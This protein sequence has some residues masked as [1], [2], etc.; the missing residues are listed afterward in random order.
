MNKW[1]KRFMEMT[2]LVADWSSCYKENRKVGA[3]IVKNKR[4]LTTGYNGAPAGIKSCM[5]R[6]ECLRNKLNIESGKM[7]EL[8]YA[9][10]A[11]QNAIIQAARLGISLEGAEL[12]CTHQPCVIC[13]KMIINSGIVRVV[14]D[15]GYPDDFALELFAESGVRLELYS[16]LEKR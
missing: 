8:C 6:G 15:Q 5:E 12:Y 10:H 13:A 1:D 11:E 2:K 9:V 16:D 14:Y 4:I 3:I 7:L